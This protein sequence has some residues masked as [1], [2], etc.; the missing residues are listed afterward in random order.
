MHSEIKVSFF[1]EGFDIHPDELTKLL[2]IKPDK[3][4][5]DGALLREIPK[6]LFKKGHLWSLYANDFSKNI[7]DQ[8]MS[9]LNKI[10]PFKINFIEASKKYNTYLMCLVESYE[11]DRPSIVFNKDIV[12]E[13]ADM[14]TEISIDLYIYD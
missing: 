7:E 8:T 9:I 2:G 10:K 12:K 4:Q 3:I 14:N 11:G 5:E 13:L 6:K 1:Y